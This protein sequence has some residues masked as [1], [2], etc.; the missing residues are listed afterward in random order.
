VVAVVLVVLGLV[1]L[2]SG[3]DDGDSSAPTTTGPSTTRQAPTT[4]TPSTTTPSST[5]TAGEIDG[6]GETITVLEL[7]MA[8]CWDDPQSEDL[9]DEIEVLPCDEPHDYEVF[10]VFDAADG[11]FDRATVSDGANE[12]C[13]AAF[14]A[15]VGIAYEESRLGFFPLI[16]TADGWEAG[17]RE[18]LCSLADSGG[19]KLV[20]TMEGTGT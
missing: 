19:K 2:L 18:V 3:G 14:D 4:K 20:G 1:L 10:E 8:D 7:A 9:V 13:L 6:R 16:P 15:F 17:D 5:T 11:E 12:R